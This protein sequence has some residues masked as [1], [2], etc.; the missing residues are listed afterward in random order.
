MEKETRSY[1]SRATQKARSLLEQDYAEQLEGQF[2][3]GINGEISPEAGEHLDERQRLIRQKIVATIHHLQP[4]MGSATAAVDRYRREATFTTLNR[5]VALKMLESRNLVQECISKGEQSSGFREFTGLAPGLAKLPDKGYRLYL[6]SLFD[7]IGQEV[8]VL[9]DRLDPVSFLWPRRPAL[10]KLLEILNGTELATVW[11]EDETIGWVYQYFN[12]DEE[13]KQMRAESQAPR[14]SRELAVR[15]QFFTP[16]YVVEFLTDNT[17]GRIWYE[18]RQGNTRLVDECDYLIR[19]PVEVFLEAGETAPESLENSEAELSQEELLNQPVYIPF[20]P[21]KDPRDLKVLDPACGSGH[22]L[23]YA[24]DLLLTIYEES[25]GLENAPRSEITGHTL[26]EDYTS[27]EDLQAAIPNLILRHNLHGVEIDPRAAQIASLALWMRS[28]R[29]YQEMGFSRNARSQIQKTNVVVAEPMPGDEN[30]VEEFAETLYPP[31]VGDLFRRIVK[32]MKLAGEAGSL[33][34]IEESIASTVTEAREQ[35]QRWQQELSKGYLPG[36]EPTTVQGELDLSGIDDVSF[37][38][39]MEGRIIGALKQYA[40]KAQNG[41]GF[42]RRLFAEDAAR[43]FG[44]IDLCYYDYDVVLMNPPFGYAPESI[45][46]KSGN[47]GI[48]DIDALFVNR[49]LNILSNKGFLG[50]ITNRTQLMRPSLANFRSHCLQQQGKLRVCVDLGNGVLDA[51][52]ETATFVVERS[53]IRQPGIFSNSLG[54]RNKEIAVRNCTTD[55]ERREIDPCV[56][57]GLPDNRFA[58]WIHPIL[59]TLLKGNLKL[60][61]NCHVAFGVST[62]DNFR[63]LRL[64]WEVHPNSLQHYSENSKNGWIPLAKGGDYSPYIGDLHLV[65]DWRGNG[66]ALRSMPGAPIRNED[67]YGLSGLTFTKRTASAFAPRILPEGCIIEVNGPAIISKQRANFSRLEFLGIL[68]SRVSS[69]FSDVLVAAGDTSIAGSAAKDYIPGVI[70][71]LPLPVL[72][73][74]DLSVLIEK[75]VKIAS[76]IESY[77]ETSAYFTGFP[78]LFCEKDDL[79]NRF[80]VCGKKTIAMLIEQARLAAESLQLVEDAFELPQHVRQEL[81]HVVGPIPGKTHNNVSHLSLKISEVVKLSNKQIV[82]LALQEGIT[83]KDISKNSFHSHRRLEL[84]SSLTGETLEAVGQYLLDDFCSPLQYIKSEISYAVGVCFGR[85]TWNPNVGLY[86]NYLSELLSSPLPLVPP[87][88]GNNQENSYTILVDDFGTKGDIISAVT[89]FFENIFCQEN[90]HLLEQIEDELGGIRLWIRNKFF[91]FHVKQYSK[92]RRKAPIYW[93]LATPT[94]SYSLWL[95]YHRFTRDTFYKALND[96]VKPKLEYEERK[97][98]S[99]TQSAGN[100]PTASQCKEIAAQETFVTELRTFRNEIE[101]IAP[102]WNPNLNDGVIIN[103][104]PLWRLVSQNRS[105]Q[106]ECK[107]CWDKLVKGDYDWA[108]L[109]LHLWPERVIPKCQTDR[110]LAIAHDLEDI[111]WEEDDKGKWHPRTVE[112][113]TIENLIQEHTSPAVKD[114][115][116]RLLEAPEPGG[117]RS[118]RT[119]RK[120]S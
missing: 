59:L 48:A 35:Y 76:R 84:I 10:L 92:S 102:L 118:R 37:F 83:R 53:S 104:A 103:F 4:Q 72:V 28:Q 30:L 63:Y 66:A 120:T 117:N 25:W 114:A 39:E 52:V 15:N 51:L 11:G 67:V 42:Q 50:V 90:S 77:H 113:A 20:R 24:F 101:T 115:L 107:A 3:I 46:L 7:E 5:F 19:R 64:R 27:L 80:E 119:R 73:K 31:V 88:Y 79:V 1:I 36:F 45:L 82:N 86:E 108:H 23:L 106:K 110:S 60:R 8:R 69:Y 100:N 55:P 99:F 111:F 98:S 78:S 54:I 94:A 6:E 96:F 70:G 62:T 68:S 89:T 12:R 85:W 109:A 97:L 95:Y 29:A 32:E 112:S 18:M 40:E 33:L 57:A 14:N 44:F 43:G 34:K 41:Q 87:G 21:L 47:S 74:S 75:I 22:F 13:R 16:R 49:A 65:I 58:H 9:F 93:Q 2:D 91:D 81:D 71:L 61:E 105:W 26:Q 116:K 38:Q 56:F 17:L